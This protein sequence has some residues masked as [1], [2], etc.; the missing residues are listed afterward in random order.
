M[1]KVFGI[2]Y[3]TTCLVNGKIYIG[4]N[5]TGNKNYL[6]SGTLVRAAI[7]KY[8]R[9]NFIRETLIECYNQSELDEWEDLL[10][11]EYKSRDRNIGYN[12]AKGSVLG[13]IGEMSPTKLPEVR[14]KMR[15]A[16]KGK[17][18]SEETKTKM[19]E[20]KKGKKRSEETRRKLS[21]AHK[22]KILSEK[23]RRKLSECNKGK[24][25]SEETRNKISESS[26][27]ISEET[28][29]KMSAAKK[30]NKYMLGKKCSEKTKDKM[31]AAHKGKTHSEETREKLSM[32]ILQYDKKGNI[33]AEYYGA[34]EAERQTE[35]PNTNIISC[36]KGR[37]QS[38]GGYI[39][40]YK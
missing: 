6:G 24:T 2:I 13:A 7:K 35:I 21:E 37:L 15:A 27:N 29:A 23:T 3:K 39:W 12:I 11:W 26:K 10:I 18:L 8:G 16:N 32:P 25:L 30:G 38:A 14:A 34:K 28:R 20:A 19:S 4:Q 9:E 22:G 33:I 40:K 5:T 36:C 17:I 31:R 1:E